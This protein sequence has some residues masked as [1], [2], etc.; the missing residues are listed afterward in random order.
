MFQKFLR[1]FQIS[2]SRQQTTRYPK[3]ITAFLFIVFCAVSFVSLT[4]SALAATLSMDPSTG[5]FVVGSTFNVPIYVNS[6]NET[7]NAIALEAKFPPDLL[8]LVSPS[9]GQSV[10]TLWTQQPSYNNQTG[11]ISIQ[12]VIPN[13]ITTGR[14]LVTTM[15]FRVKAPGSAYLKFIDGT[16][17]LKHDGLGTDTLHQTNGAVYHLILPPPAGPIVASP[18]HPDPSQIYRTNSV[19]LSWTPEDTDVSQYSYVFNADA[20]DVPDDISEGPHANIVYRNMSD[21]RY[22]FHIRGFRRG[23]WGGTTDFAANIDT[24]PPA[25]FSVTILPNTKVNQHQQMIAQW[26]STDAFSGIDH[27]ELKVIALAPHYEGEQSQSAQPI[28][29][30]AESPYIISG[31]TAGKYDVIVRAYDK[32][33]NYRESVARIHVLIPL[34]GIF[35]DA[36]ISMGEYFFVSW[37]LIILLLL[38]VIILLGLIAW[39]VHV[40]HQEV[41]ARLRTNVLPEHVAGA[42]EALDTKKKQ[43]INITQFVIVGLMLCSLFTASPETL[44][45]ATVPLD[46]PLITTLSKNIANDEIFYVGGVSPVPGATVTIFLQNMGT[47]ETMSETVDVDPRGQWFYQHNGF[48]SAGNYVLWAQEKLGGEQS[49]PSPQEELTVTRVAIQVG[50]SRLSY[51]FIYGSIALFLLLLVCVLLLLIYSLRRMIKRKHTA[52]QKE[53][54]EAEEAV[55][56][57]FAVLKRDIE[58]ELDVV[59]KAK[60]TRSLRAEEVGKEE[61]LKRDL[62]WVEENITKEVGD[63]EKEL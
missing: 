27:Y 9:T 30:E 8:Q 42:Q 39:R 41:H 12:G 5:T 29:I 15:V 61:Q 10:I 48:L 46:T 4:P 16:K 62:A 55:R 1:T 19:F 28:F 45:A 58:A 56:T 54:R 40:R 25:E 22:F 31:L 59:R 35:N 2:N 47:G 63:I 44:R 23:A 11:T 32:A 20:V 36:G 18:T 34:F 24:T 13:G 51:E 14:G 57:G 6:E 60:L 21:G 38:L 52:W 37:W 49:P 17:V 3:H 53:V 50:A 33:G 7:I 26:D 43:Y